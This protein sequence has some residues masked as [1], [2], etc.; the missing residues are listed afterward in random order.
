MPQAKHEHLTPEGLDQILGHDR[1]DAVNRLLFH[2]L[3]L[4]PECA[5]AGGH[6]LAAY[7]AGAIGVQ[8]SFVEAD[9]F[10]SRTEAP[11]FFAELE[12]LSSEDRLAL[13]EEDRRYVHWG[14]V[15]LLAA[16]SREAGTRD[17]SLAVALAHLGVEA[18]KRLRDGQPCEKHW[19]YELR[20]YA[21][22]H[23]AS[24]YR[25]SGDLR[26][27]ER[28]LKESERWW[29]KGEREVGDVLGYEPVILGL[30]ASLRK[31]QR[32][33][34]EA[35]TLLDT[36]IGTYLAG[37]PATQDFH[38]AG[39][40][41]VKKAKVLEEMGNLEEALDLLRE[42]LPLIDPA[43]EPRLLVCVWQNVVNC[44]AKLGR[45]EE[46]KALLP[47][48][49]ALSEELGNDLD[50]VRLDWTEGLIRSA[51]G[52]FLEAAEALAR[53]RQEFVSRGIGFDAALATLDLAFILLKEER[54]AEVAKLAREM[55]PIFEAQDVHREALAALAVF[56]R[57]ALHET[58]TAELVER[59]A[60]Y[61]MR[62]RKDPGLRFDER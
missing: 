59:L 47:K 3:A 53:V 7:E 6:I 40:A 37:D 5:A 42:A 46:A 13:V 19:L 51:L 11:G 22:A 28:A 60:R 18:A 62:A 10:R 32:R 41:F 30:A 33:F 36:V 21:F 39:R 49:R 43:R 23:L 57:A 17:P 26:E 35:L 58:A 48:V 9:L 12:A 52:E 2:A 34:D 56:Q 38:L 44:L 29:K 61:L 25:V 45:P 15:E 31:D 20:G 4:C 16:K 55:L 54:T 8:F 27:A 24:A 1:Q 14:L 50:L